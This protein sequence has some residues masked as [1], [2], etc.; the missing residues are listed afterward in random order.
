MPLQMLLHM[1]L[2]HYS[3]KIVAK[4]KLSIYIQVFDFLDT[5]TLGYLKNKNE[6]H[7]S[8]LNIQ[9]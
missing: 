3:M 9:C 4:L 8:S 6:F 2:L 1:S 5:F 7:F